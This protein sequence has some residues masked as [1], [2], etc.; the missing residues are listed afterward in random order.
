LASGLVDSLYGLVFAFEYD[1]QYFDDVV[2]SNFQPAIDGVV[3][4]YSKPGREEYIV[5]AMDRRNKPVQS[6][7]I[8]EL[9]FFGGYNF[10]FSPPSDTVVMRITDVKAVL[11]DGTKLE[12]RG[13]EVPVEIVLELTSTSNPAHTGFQIMPNPSNGR[14]SFKYEPDLYDTPYSVYAISGQLVARGTFATARSITLDPGL[15]V[16][17]VHSDKAISQRVVVLD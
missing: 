12:L 9:S 5:V 6:E 2:S 16:V 10:D 17:V 4:R 11:A 3:R 15:Y 7:L 14:I 13:Q 1:P 8:V